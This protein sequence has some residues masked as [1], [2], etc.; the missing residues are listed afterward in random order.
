MKKTS[1]DK[2]LERYITGQ[3]SEQ[4]KRKIE[5][6]LDVK[7][8]DDGA[9]FILSESDEERLFQKITANKDN[10]SEIQSFR[11]GLGRNRAFFKTTWFRMAAAILLLA[12]CTYA[13]RWLVVKEKSPASFF[14]TNGIQ[15]EIL[16]DGSIV[17]LHENSTLTYMESA[18]GQRLATLKGEG[19]F[20]IAKDPSRPFT[21][22]CGDASVRVVGTSF[23]LKANDVGLE[24]KVLTGRVRLMTSSNT[25]GID[26]IPNE[27][28]T[29]R[30][31]VGL[32]KADM[33][34]GEVTAIT[35][36]TDYDMA[37]K[38]TAIKTVVARIQRKFDVDVIIDNPGVNDCRITAD[39]TDHSLKS[40]MQ[41]IR[42][43]LDIDFEIEKSTVTISGK[44]CS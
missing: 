9:D 14:S 25:A 20:E 15:R 3:V 34:I 38:N 19:L 22:A 40:T 42:E 23:N 36:S 35:A 7:K 18:D 4:E 16:G 37:F 1:L 12:G 27:T 17:W 8:T 32:K 44:G 26:V 5:A 6:W 24:L 28:A 10:L 13:I 33:G 21:I 41:M 29:Y 43:L 2:L 39:F 31:D 30:K 11:P